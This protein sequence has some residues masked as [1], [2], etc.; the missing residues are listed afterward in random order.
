METIIFQEKPRLRQPDLL[1]GFGGWANAG[2][3][4]IGVLN[5]L[6]QSLRLKKF[7]EIDS[8]NYYDHTILRPSAVIKEGLIKDLQ[9]STNEYF[10]FINNKSHHDL[11]I[12]QGIEPNL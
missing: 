7:A 6:K 8:H 3:A 2:E 12:F 9:L 11:V 4:S 10:F 1:I 5:Y